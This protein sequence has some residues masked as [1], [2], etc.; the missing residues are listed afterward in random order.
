MYSKVINTGR[1]KHEGKA[2][3]RR[4]QTQPPKDEV[5]WCWSVFHITYMIILFVVL[6]IG[7]IYV[8]C[9]F[10]HL[11]N[12][13]QRRE[14][15]SRHIVL[16]GAKKE[17]Q[18][19]TREPTIAY[20]NTTPT[21]PIASVTT[22][23]PK[24]AATDAVNWIALNEQTTHQPRHRRK[25]KLR[26]LIVHSHSSALSA[27][28]LKLSLKRDK[29][30]SGV[31][32]MRRSQMEIVNHRFKFL[33]RRYD[34]AIPLLSNAYFDKPKGKQKLTH[35]QIRMLWKNHTRLIRALMDDGTQNK[36]ICVSPEF[37]TYSVIKPGMNVTWMG[38]Y[39][40]LRESYENVV[41]KP[42]KFIT[43][44]T[45]LYILRRFE[46]KAPSTSPCL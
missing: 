34:F 19:V 23:P 25:N 42:S 6:L 8:A 20:T 14:G 28:I 33:L 32:T 15:P 2:N 31:S 10:S 5:K 17:T 38:D 44:L 22:K 13:N 16:P 29:R 41:K 43:H 4:G 9:F 3:E 11:R 30:V 7:I 45:E 26:L 36:R 35:R 12:S 1:N 18:P 37:Y 21:I 40:V 27:M 39:Y 46:T 24:L